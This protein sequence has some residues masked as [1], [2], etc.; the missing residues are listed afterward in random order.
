MFLLMGRDRKYIEY[1]YKGSLIYIFMKPAS[2]ES[3]INI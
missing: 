2:F 1:I 3:K